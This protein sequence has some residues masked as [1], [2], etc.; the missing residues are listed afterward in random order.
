MLIRNLMN[1]PQCRELAD[2]MPSALRVIGATGPHDKDINGTYVHD[3]FQNQVRSMFS[4]T[5]SHTLRVDVVHVCRRNCIANTITTIGRSSRLRFIPCMPGNRLCGTR[6]LRFSPPVRPSETG[7]Q[8]PEC[9]MIS[10]RSPKG[11]PDLNVVS[12]LIIH[13]HVNLSSY[14]GKHVL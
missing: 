4:L 3:G 5:C 13:K 11:K 7:M 2:Q 8:W 1:F 9:W 12:W 6:W 10:H 14:R